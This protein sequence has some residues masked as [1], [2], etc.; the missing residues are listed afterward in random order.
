MTKLNQVIPQLIQ[1][2]EVEEEYE[3]MYAALHD[4]EDDPK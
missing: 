1:D 4:S 2:D 3:P